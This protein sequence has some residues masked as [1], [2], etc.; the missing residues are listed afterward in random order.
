MAYDITRKRLSFLK[1]YWY[2]VHETVHPE[3][4][5]YRK[6][7]EAK[8]Q[9]VATLVAGGDVED[10]S[11]KQE[12]FTRDLLSTN[13]N[14]SILRHHRFVVKQLGRKLEDYREGWELCYVVYCALLGKC[15]IVE[16][17]MRG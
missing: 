10:D 11:G 5:V 6:L 8:V 1:D 16:I 3:T 17:W 14:N 13:P 9:F 4:D 7:K 12:T 2:A 15:C